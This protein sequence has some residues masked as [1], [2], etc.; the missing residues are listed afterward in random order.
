MQAQGCDLSHAN[1]SPVNTV[2]LMELHEFRLVSTRCTP[3][4]RIAEVFPNTS[5]TTRLSPPLIG[6]DA[7]LV[8]LMKPDASLSTIYRMRHV[9]NQRISNRCSAAN[10][11][12]PPET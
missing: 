7:P 11:T 9:Q 5:L 10:E 2:Q 1:A 12:T 8:S 4:V 6:T 3:R